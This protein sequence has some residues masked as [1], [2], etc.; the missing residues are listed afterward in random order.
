MPRKP[1]VAPTCFVPSCPADFVGQAG[2]VADVLMRKAERLRTNP[3]QPLKLLISGA[4]GIGKTSL[5]NMIARTLGPRLQEK[6]GGTFIVENKAGAG[7]TVGVCSP[8]LRGSCRANH[9]PRSRHTVFGGQ[10]KHCG[11]RRKHTHLRLEFPRVRCEYLEHHGT[12][13]QQSIRS[14]CCCRFCGAADRR[15]FGRQSQNSGAAAPRVH[16]RQCKL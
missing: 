1:P 13:C 15:Q 4:P 5:V 7:G 8:P 2:K 12:E 6:L 9:A 10:P 16:L 11:H 3:D 14:G